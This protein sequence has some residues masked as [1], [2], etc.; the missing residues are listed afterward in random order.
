MWVGQ[1]Q[2]HIGFT[3]GVSVEETNKTGDVRL[4][5]GYH[6]R[7]VLLDDRRCTDV[8]AFTRIGIYESNEFLIGDVEA[9]DRDGS[10]EEI[11]AT[12]SIIGVVMTL[13]GI[14][15]KY[16]TNQYYKSSTNLLSNS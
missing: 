14:V 11:S 3:L 9:Y 12:S 13:N 4:T 1:A 15:R 8:R 5:H 7:H 16:S 2:F 6:A 10:Q